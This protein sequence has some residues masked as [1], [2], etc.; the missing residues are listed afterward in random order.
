LAQAS[1][2]RGD[3]HAKNLTQK[4]AGEDGGDVR[5]T[6]RQIEGGNQD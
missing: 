5:I 3:N 6:I 4:A 1:S 2:R